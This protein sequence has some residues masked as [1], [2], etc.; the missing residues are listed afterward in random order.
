MVRK[1]NINYTKFEDRH[2]WILQPKT[3]ATDK[4]VFYVHGCAYVQNMIS[5]QWFMV[6]AIISRTNATFIIPDYDLAPRW[7]YTKLFSFIKNLYLHVLEKNAPEKVYLLGD[8]AG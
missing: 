3:G 1:L 4:V 5:F 2:Y 7:T 8:S 6:G